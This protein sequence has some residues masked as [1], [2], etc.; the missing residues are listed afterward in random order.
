MEPVFA[1]G[2]GEILWDVL[3]Y[4][5]ML[6]GAPANFAYH[7]NGLGG[8]GVPVSCVG[9]DKL[10][11]EALSLLAS[12]GVNIDGISIDP[13]HPTGTVNARIDRHGVATYA[14]SDDVAWDFL[15]LNDAAIALAAKAGAVCFGTLAQ[16]S[17][18]SRRAIHQFLG[19]ASRALRVY[20]INLRQS[21]YTPEVIG[22]SLDVAD[23]L[24][25]NDD[26]LVLVRKMLSLPVGEREALEALMLRH[27]LKLAVLTRGDKGSLIMSPDEV[28]DL[29]GVPVEVVDTI[30]AGDSFTAAMVLAYLDGQSLDEINEYATKV[31]AYVC[32]CS[33]A[34]PEIPD[35][36]KL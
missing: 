31:A 27:S 13:V 29:P 20:D 10:G 2:L 17:E 15:S 36:Y 1:V 9:D 34:M 25:I 21:F 22:Q 35:S 14:F 18:V 8:A 23:V 24:K 5:R 26:E 7:M 30:G 19:A 16:R 33:G 12:H 28:S 11:R 6:G 32:G 3:P 4:K